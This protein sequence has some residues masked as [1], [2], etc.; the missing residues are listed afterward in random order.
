MF[1]QNAIFPQFFQKVQIFHTTLSFLI[2]DARR[3]D[4]N[5]LKVPRVTGFPGVSAIINSPYV[6]H[7][8]KWALTTVSAIRTF[9]GITAPVIIKRHAEVGATYFSGD[10][11]N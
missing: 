9:R 1:L 5:S 2:A 6:H 7:V 4:F 10:A 11:K 3:L 8:F